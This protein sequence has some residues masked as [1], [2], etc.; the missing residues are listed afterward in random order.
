MASPAVK[1][2]FH[3]LAAQLFRVLDSYDILRIT[4]RI[5]NGFYAG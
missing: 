1:G 4:R 5:E 3:G 2:G